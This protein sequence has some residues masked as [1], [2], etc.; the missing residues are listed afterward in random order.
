MLRHITSKQ[1]ASTYK[2]EHQNIC[3]KMLGGLGDC[4][5]AASAVEALKNQNKN[6][7]LACPKH[8]VP[9][10]RELGVHSVALPELNSPTEQQKYD[11]IV[12][13]DKVF[14]DKSDTKRLVNKEY[15][16]AVGEVLELDLTPITCTTAPLQVPSRVYLHPGA[17]NPNRRWPNSNWEELANCLQLLGFQVVWLGAPDEFGYNSV[18]ICKLSDTFPELADQISTLKTKPGAFIGND[19]GFAHVA[20]VLSLPGLVL[21]GNTI[22]DNVIFH[23][24]SL[25]AAYH[26]RPEKSSRSRDVA[27]TDGLETISVERVL[28]KFITKALQERHPTMPVRAKKKD[29][30]YVAEDTLGKEIPQWIHKNFELSLFMPSIS[31][32]RL[33]RD[34][35]GRLCLETEAQVLYINETHPEVAIR[36]LREALSHARKIK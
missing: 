20:G 11:C 29:F 24:D 7:I 23:Y 6:S 1:I 28:G 9:A 12:S 3:I 31:S 4:I 5:V 10:M 33:S 8:F 13:L 2:P 14:I 17:S 25:F 35:T 15:Y 36:G 26:E 18:R 34:S 30:L 19:S 27:C 32:H 22:P 16:L 21:F